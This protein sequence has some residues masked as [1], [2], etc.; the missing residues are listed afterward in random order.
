MLSFSSSGSVSSEA[1]T[2]Q[3]TQWVHLYNNPRSINKAYRLVWQ[4]F[5]M[6][7]RPHIHFSWNAHVY[8][9]VLRERISIDYECAVDPP[10]SRDP[11]HLALRHSYRVRKKCSFRR[12]PTAVILHKMLIFV[13]YQQCRG[14]LPPQ[15]ILTVPFNLL[16]VHTVMIDSHRKNIRKNK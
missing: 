6:P 3:Y 7:A 10:I 16:S 15:H 13:P 2:S 8:R 14:C 11:R 1:T 5:T 9:L 4:H 12:N